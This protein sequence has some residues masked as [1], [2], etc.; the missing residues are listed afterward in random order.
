MQSDNEIKVNLVS[1][2]Y[3]YKTISQRPPFMTL[4]QE[5]L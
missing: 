4:K 5:Y 2:E 1:N 3:K